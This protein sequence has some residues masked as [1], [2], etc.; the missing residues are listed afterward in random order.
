MTLSDFQRKLV[1]EG[2]LIEAGWAAMKIAAIP[3]GASPLQLQELRYAFFA[4]A[5]HM[6]ACIGAILGDTDTTHADEN[7]RRMDMIEQEME[8]FAEEFNS[9]RTEMLRKMDG[10][11]H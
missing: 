4:G 3:P 7:S 1:D 5:Q 10:Y 6:L 11:K 8:K 9:R 2:K